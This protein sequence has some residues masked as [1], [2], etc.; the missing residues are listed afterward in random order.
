MTLLEMAERYR[1]SAGLIRVRIIALRDASRRAKPRERR[2]LEQRMQ[3]LQ[4]LYE[5]T[6]RTAVVLERYY[7]GRGKN[8]EKTDGGAL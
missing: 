7:I 8:G 3:A 2:E 5:D 6:R 4:S 1:A